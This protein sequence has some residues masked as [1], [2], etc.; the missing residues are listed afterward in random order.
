MPERFYLDHNATTPQHPAVT[1]A[2]AEVLAAA[3]ANPSSLHASGRAARA[4]LESSRERIAAALDGGEGEL[5]FTSGA[6][7]ANALAIL[8]VLE[9]GLERRAS[10]P[11]SP[12]IRGGAPHAVV[13]R[14]EHPSTREVYRRLEESGRVEV[15]WVAPS[16]GGRIDP[17]AM[18]AAIRPSTAIVSLLHASNETGVIQ[19]VEELSVACR[20]QGVALHCDSVQTLGKVPLSLRRLGAALVSFSAHKVYGP[21]G[22]G[23]LWIRRGCRFRHPFGGGPQ[24]KGRRPG[25]ENVAA[26][27]GFARALEVLELPAPE[28]R[29]ALWTE[30]RRRCGEVELNGDPAFLI[31]NTLNVSFAG[32]RA[33]LLL[34][35]LDLAGVEASSGSACSSGAREPSEVLRAMGLPE[36]RVRSAVRFSLGRG[37]GALEIGRAAEIIGSCVAE[38]RRRS[39]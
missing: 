15:S 12:P 35:R 38:L 6:S 30:L 10:T 16:S 21:K 13:S 5:V 37:I 11:G 23:A 19:A 20:R 18:A 14:V 1:E 29:D 32:L 33:D 7:E 36:E 31:P 34:I 8:G 24:E 3:F 4:K 9:A 39:R 25:T 27:A 2:M 22:I 17:G 28:L 26:A